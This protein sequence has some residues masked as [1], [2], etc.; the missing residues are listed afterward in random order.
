MVVGRSSQVV[1]GRERRSSLDTIKNTNSSD[2]ISLSFA[3]SLAAQGVHESA[4][5]KQQEKECCLAASDKVRKMEDYMNP[6][7]RHA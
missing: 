3:R 2:P 4:A 1:T 6:S 5:W 7:V